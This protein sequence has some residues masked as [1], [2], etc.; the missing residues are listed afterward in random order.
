MASWAYR[1]STEGRHVGPV[2]EDFAAAFGLGDGRSIAGIDADGIA[3]AAIQGLDA[4]LEA[5]NRALRARIERLER[6]LD[7]MTRE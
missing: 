7:R 1:N 3:F 2:A 6:K 5:E 4:K